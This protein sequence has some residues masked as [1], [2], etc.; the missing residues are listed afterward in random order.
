MHNA[1]RVGWLLGA[2]VLVLGLVMGCSSNDSP[3]SGGGG[4]GGVQN[5]GGGGGGV[6]STLKITTTELPDASIATAYSTT[7][8]ASG[9]HTPYSWKVTQGSLPAG[10]TLA[11]S[12]KLAGTPTALGTSKFT[13]QVTDASSPVLTASAPF[14][15][16]V[17]KVW[18]IRHDGGDNKQC[19]GTTNAAYPGSGTGVA[20]AY[21]HPFQMLGYSGAWT[22]F[23]EGDV[24]EFDD[25]PSNTEPYYIGEQNGGV[26]MDW[27]PTLGGIRPPPNS[28]AASGAA[29][30]LPVLPSHTTVRGQNF[31]RCHTTGH[32]GLVN[33]TVLS[34]IN[35]VFAVFQ[36]GG[37]EGVAISCIEVTQPDTCTSAGIGSGPGQCGSTSNYVSYA[38][39]MLAYQTS[40]GPA[41]MT[42]TD[43]AVVG[44]S[45]R[46]IMGSHL[47]LHGSDTFTASDVY[48]IGN[49]QSGW[50]G[51][52]GGCD[53]SCESVGTMNISY[54]DIEWNGCMAVKPYDIG[55]SP[56]ANP[57][58]FNYC[59]AQ[60]TGGYGDGFV[61]LAAGDLTLNVTHW[62][63]NTTPR[64]GSTRPI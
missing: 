23:G 16:T 14:S 8:A 30:V 42:L 43:F 21:N 19:T 51:D 53:N 9:G 31:G 48:L 10:L 1:K 57:N 60:N 12:G 62:C 28:P 63:S 5:Q 54:A 6:E 58:G 46:G 56:E 59:Y 11:A 27:Q 17:A 25:P 38:G 15:I 13:V 20:C 22:S 47:N 45:N 37:T 41:N 2:S 44:T 39:L 49:G 52:G 29:C 24:L 35:G 40:Q 7:F 50:D 32:T 33:P 36:V 26:G 34:G 61:Q 64:T 3:G 18:H 4:G 55:V